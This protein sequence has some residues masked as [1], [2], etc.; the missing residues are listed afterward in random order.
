VPPLPLPPLLLLL[1]LLCSDACTE[2][3]S[4]D[5]ADEVEMLPGSSWGLF[6]ISRAEMVGAPLEAP[7]LLGGVGLLA[8]LLREA[9]SAARALSLE[10][11]AVNVVV[12]GLGQAR[13]AHRRWRRQEQRTV[14]V[15]AGP[16]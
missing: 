12:R 7:A 2:P 15:I 11:P 3:S 16:H 1:P 9:G 13:F 5:E 14:R 4:E 6:R 10:E 8:L